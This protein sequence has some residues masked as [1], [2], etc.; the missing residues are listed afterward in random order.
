MH[1]KTGF[2][3]LRKRIH[4]SEWLLVNFSVLV[5]CELKEIEEMSFELQDTESPFPSFVIVGSLLLQHELFIGFHF[6]S[7]YDITELSRR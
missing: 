6:F 4:K 2:V 5:F 3:D 1:G 7:K